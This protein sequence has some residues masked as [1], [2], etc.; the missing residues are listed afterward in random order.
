VGKEVRR[1][2]VQGAMSLVF[3]N[4]WWHHIADC[5]DWLTKARA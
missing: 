5:W 1:R 2:K 3:I 4:L